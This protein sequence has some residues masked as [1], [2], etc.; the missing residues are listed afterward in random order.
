[1][2]IVDAIG[3]LVVAILA[4]IG[5][6]KFCKAL[7]MPITV[8]DLIGIAFFSLFP[9]MNLFVM[10]MTWAMLGIMSAT[11]SHWFDWTRKRVF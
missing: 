7:G 3:Y 1:M 6:V 11:S 9:F 2:Y 8:G 10:F 4:F 5:C